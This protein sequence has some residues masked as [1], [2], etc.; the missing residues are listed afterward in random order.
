MSSLRVPHHGSTLDGGGGS[1]GNVQ[2]RRSLS[3]STAFWKRSSSPSGGGSSAKDGSTFTAGDLSAAANNSLFPP[4]AGPR[5]SSITFCGMSL[6]VFAASNAITTA[7][8]KSQHDASPPRPGVWPQLFVSPSPN[9][10]QDLDDVFTGK[11][12]GNSG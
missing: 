3:P 8:R 12:D 4:A 11:I 7:R 6:S 10:S 2:R 9:T 5:R 1:H